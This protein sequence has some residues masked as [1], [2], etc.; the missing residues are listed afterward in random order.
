VLTGAWAAAKRRHDGGEEW[1]RLEL[2]VR[3]K[4]GMRELEREGKKERWGSGVLIAFYRGWGSAREGW[5]GW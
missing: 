3:V 4:E 5:P 1:W 2:G